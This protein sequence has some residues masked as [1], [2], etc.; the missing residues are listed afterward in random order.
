[1]D[2]STSHVLLIDSNDR[3]TISNSVEDA[4][5]HLSEHYLHETKS[6]QFKSMSF[7]NTAY[8]VTSA[9]NTLA[10]EA[11]G[12]PATATVPVG[13]YTI[14]SFI[15][16]FNTALGGVIVIADNATTKKF[17]FTSPANTQIKLVGTTMKTVLGITQD[18]VVG[19]AYN[20]NVIY[21]MIRTYMVHVASNA[22]ARAD[23]LI[24]SDKKKY[25]IIASVPLDVGWGY[26]KFHE[27]SL[28]TSDFSLFSGLRN[29]S[30]IDIRLLGDD[31]QE[32][33]LNGSGYVLEF[34]VRAE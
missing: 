6:V 32:F 29:L 11:L 3:S 13:Q 23:N 15:T 19:V 1:M 14:S 18:T 7:S 28:D 26:V 31:M 16:A 20:A 5:Y 2:H 30:S 21:S 22:L 12:V 4:V 24:K 27:E 9:N 34:V 17:S 33:N 8:N 10:Y 25:A